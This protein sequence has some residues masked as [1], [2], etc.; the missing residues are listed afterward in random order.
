MIVTNSYKGLK[1]KFYNIVVGLGNF[2]GIHIGHKKLVKEVV[3]TAKE[4][5][6]TAAIITFN[7]CPLAVLDPKNA[8][9]RLLSQQYKVEEMESLG[10]DLMISIPFN[11]DFAKLTPEEFI[12]EVLYN[13]LSVRS[14]VVGYNYTFGYRG[15][16]TPKTIEQFALK[17]GYE[18]K[19]IPPVTID[20]QVV[21]STVIRKMLMD[22]KIELANRFLGREHFVDGVVRAGDGIGKKIG[23]PTANVDL[24]DD[25]LLPQN[26]VY[27]VIAEIENSSYV[28]VANIGCKPT[29]DNGVNRACKK[30]SLEV[31]ILDFQED[32]Y[33]KYI[34]IKFM[35]RIRDEKKFNSVDELVDQIKCDVQLARRVQKVVLM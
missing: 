23:F 26:G 10:I 2:D 24:L 8:P 3:D 1:E 21:S 11:L 27:V 15:T 14:V 9:P 18:L 35:R 4:L 31:H 33:E 5:S 13:E 19:I 22:G 7:P 32:V 12:E 30:P 28:G 17:Y 34:K 25:I 6:G 20:G 29:F 16:G